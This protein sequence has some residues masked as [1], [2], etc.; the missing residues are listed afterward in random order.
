MMDTL[1]I[2]VVANYFII[3]II[4]IINFSSI[5]ITQLNINLL[6]LSIVKVT[7]WRMRLNALHLYNFSKLSVLN[8]IR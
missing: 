8:Q 6:S 3:I 4:I 7:E 1:R 2:S 5:G